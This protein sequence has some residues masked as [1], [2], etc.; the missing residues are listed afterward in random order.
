MQ[1]TNQKALLA[2]LLAGVLMGALDLAIIGPAL[3][4]IQ[5][6][7]GMTSRG[8][9][10]LF[11]LY[12][13][14]Q[15]VGTPL[16]AKLSDRLGPR[17]I[18]IASITLFAL[19]SLLLV[20][21]PDAGWLFVGRVIQGF[22]GAGIFPVAVAV[23]GDVYPPEKRGSVLG[24]LGA[25][26]GIAFLIGPILGGILLQFAWQ[27]LFLINIPIA[28]ALIAGAWFLLPRGTI[29]KDHKAFDLG[30]AVTLS[31]GLTSLAIAITNL[32]MTAI[33]TSLKE[34][35]VWPFLL[36]FLALAPWFWRFEKSADDPIIKPAF[37]NNTQITMAI[38]IS[39]GIG[40]MQSASAFYP[41][42]AVSAMGISE[43]NAAWLLLPGVLITTIASPLVGALVNRIGTRVLVL[44]GLIAI[45]IGFMMFGLM[46]ISVAVFITAGCIAGLGFASALGAPMRVVVL[47][48]ARA[49]DRGAAQGL[50]NVSINIG[51]LLGAALVGGITAS[52]GGGAPG[53][54]A[55]Y[56]VMGVMTA[57]LIVLALR[58]RRKS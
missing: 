26:F 52:Q 17:P 34:I 14:G 29:G 33:L 1:V 27:W 11:N 16:L 46:E 49:E 39:M 3:P 7:F 30:G 25:V 51:Q 47:N 28:I 50:L 56:T 54:Q 5:A 38:S 21:G 36:C 20:V 55:T 45:A 31:V 12:V 18:Y 57:L 44:F 15:L 22:G 10:W 40:A 58:L 48:E 42:L 37:F 53:Y 13:L 35:Q 32:D 43:A 41:A 6:E 2:L 24:L 9:A 8:L 19:G 23:I 4:A